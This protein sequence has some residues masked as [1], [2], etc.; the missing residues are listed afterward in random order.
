[1]TWVLNLDAR[2]RAKNIARALGA[3]GNDMRLVD[4]PDPSELTGVVVCSPESSDLPQVLAAT[5]ATNS[6][7][8]VVFEPGADPDPWSILATGATDLM[9]WDGDPS[10]IQARLRRLREVEQTVESAVESEGVVGRSPALRQ[11]MRE[12]VT[13]AKFGRGPILILGETGTGKELAARVAHSVSAASQSG[14]MVTV[15]STTIVPTLSGS[16]LFGH[17]RGAFTGAVSVR[18][19]ACAAADG[20]TLFL[21]EVGELSLELQPAML[22]MAQD[23]KYKRV[24]GDKWLHSRFRLI[25]ATNRSL[26]AEVADGRFRADFYYRIAATTVTMPLLR[27]RVEDVIPLFMKFFAQAQPRSRAEP[28][29]LTPAVAEALRQRDYP[30]NLRDLRQLARRVAARHAGVGPITPGDLPAPDRPP[31]PPAPPAPRA[32]S[33][34]PVPRRVPDC[35]CASPTTLAESV[36][37]M[38]RQGMTLKDLRE[39]VADLAVTAA[40]EQSGGNVRAAAAKLGVT[41]RALHLRRAQRREAEA[42]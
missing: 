18:T 39:Q 20:G 41:D 10:P 5:A 9:I 3:S 15:D 33:A 42:S 28:V 38:L 21:D 26:E 2:P 23:G 34:L 31:A 14:E 19:G 25:C 29:Q 17:E 11:A 16:E 32:L 13:A 36:R 8:I 7:V 4:A 12:V 35:D 30:G 40:L 24:G 27:Q 1:M 22:R 37:A 6:H